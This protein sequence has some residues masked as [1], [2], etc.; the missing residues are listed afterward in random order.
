MKYKCPKC[1]N[2]FE[3]EAKF[4]S[5][6][7]QPFSFQ[8]K[9]EEEIVVAPIG[10]PKEEPKPIQI[11]EPDPSVKENDEISNDEKQADSADSIISRN[12]KTIKSHVVY[13]IVS[14]FLLMLGM[15]LTL[16]IPFLSETITIEGVKTSQT[17]S[18]FTIVVSYIKTLA[19][20]ESLSVFSIPSASI[21]SIIVVTIL[22][23]III[24]IVKIV[25][26]FNNLRDLNNYAYE[27]YD[28]ILNNKQGKNE[29]SFAYA[30]GGMLSF[31]N[32]SYNL[33]GISA[34]LIVMLVYSKIPYI[35]GGVPYDKYNVWIIIPLLALIAT[36]IFVVIDHVKFSPFKKEIIKNKYKAGKK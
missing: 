2:V 25:K 34:Y 3:E 28:K 22:V 19:E 9:E 35:S 27:L 1:G 21:L 24:G 31:T 26:N 32:V 10:V 13:T 29:Q 4:C 6:C 23:S 33:I 5:N 7:G 16:F 15:L 17:H 14:N 18:F 30:N 12:S 36:L 20:G 11:E 8:S